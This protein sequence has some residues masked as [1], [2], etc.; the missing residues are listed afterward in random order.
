MTPLAIP[1]PG[2][3]AGPHHQLRRVHG[4]SPE[5]ALHPGGPR[6]LHP[7]VH[8]AVGDR[9]HDLDQPEGV[10]GG[11]R[12]PGRG[13][14]AALLP[15]RDPQQRAGHPGRRADGVHPVDRRV[16][17]DL[18]AAHAPDQDPARGAGRQL[19]VDAP[20]DRLGLHHRVLPDDHPAAPRHAVGRQTSQKD[21]RHGLH[22]FLPGPA[23]GAVVVSPPAERPA[24]ESHGD[25]ARPCAWSHA[26][27][28]SRTAPARSNPST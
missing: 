10:R 2:H 17:P 19:R 13:L 12:E 20:G 7:A 25:R 22:R 5:L 16:Q 15:H 23:G 21:L 18:D 4:V 28:P 3:R 14:L 9:D 6:H 24:A 27:R 11:R 26:P 1:G 8:G